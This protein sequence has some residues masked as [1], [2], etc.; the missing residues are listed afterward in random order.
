MHSET[1]WIIDVKLRAQLRLA[2]VFASV[3]T[4]LTSES[5]V[6]EYHLDPKRMA[7]RS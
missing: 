7:I 5:E 2:D 4:V 3:P 6:F 1:K